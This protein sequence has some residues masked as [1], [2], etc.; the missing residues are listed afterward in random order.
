MTILVSGPASETNAR[1]FLP[2][3]KLNGSTGTGFAAPI[4]GKCE[5]ASA[6]GSKIVKKGSMCFFG[7]SVN[8]PA[9][10]AVGSPSLSAT[11]PCATS[12]KIAEKIRITR[13][14]NGTAILFLELPYDII[15][16]LSKL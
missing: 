10:L 5:I 13:P 6:R 15:L 16:P 14:I 11:N 12:C 3:C 9:S 4:I 7:L 8:L 1:S 2:S